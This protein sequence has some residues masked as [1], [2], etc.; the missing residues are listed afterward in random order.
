VAGVR[1]GTWFN[2]AMEFCFPARCP[3][4]GEGFEA[5]RSTPSPLCPGCDAKLDALEAAPACRHCAAPL[6]YE[7]A[8]CPH[9]RNEGLRPFDRV[10]A[11]GL[12]DEPLRSVVHAIKYHQAWPL[13]E[14]LTSR[15]LAARG[16]RA[17][18]LVEG[19][20][21]IVAVPLHFTR[22]F[23]RG[24]NQAEL[25]AERL[26]ADGC[27][28]VARSLARVR[29]TETQTHFHSR[30]QRERNLQEAFTLVSD[31]SELRG[32]HVLLVDDV[33]T[34]GATLRAAAREVRKASPARL[35]AL[36]LAVADPRGRR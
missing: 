18:E 24:Y 15:L 32:R 21:V 29:A 3:A 14:Y 2:A 25:I 36:V 34:T 23:S 13:A 4:C 35:S 27:R 31:G 12:Y 26:K 20:D 7:D 28:R 10:T 30:A 6:A 11:L 1:L 17:R 9:C 22:Q 19:C 33:M 16:G 5:E 8:P